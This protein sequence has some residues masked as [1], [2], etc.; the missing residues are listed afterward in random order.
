MKEGKAS[1]NQA[2]AWPQ[3]GAKINWRKIVNGYECVQFERK[4][5]IGVE[6]P[7]QT[8][9]VQRPRAVVPQW[10]VAV[11]CSVKMGRLPILFLIKLSPRRRCSSKNRFSRSPRNQCAATRTSMHINQRPMHLN[12]AWYHALFWRTT[13]VEKWLPNMLE[14]KPTYIGIL[15]F[16]F[17]R[18]FWLTCKAPSQIGD[19][20]LATKLVL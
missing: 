10:R 19:L 15:L 4:G 12:K 1:L 8:M 3:K 18:F 16:G 13:A 7:A 6:Q 17:L 11:P 14:R 20:N 9:A 5:R 2:W